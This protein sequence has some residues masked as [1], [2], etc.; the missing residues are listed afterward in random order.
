MK[1]KLNWLE[2]ALLLAPFL[3]IAAFWN[4]LPARIPVHWNARGEVDGWASSKPIEIFILPLIAVAVIALLRVLPSLD[5]K[6][7]KTLQE[8]HRMHA[9]VQILR[10]ALALFFDAIFFVQIATPLG[11]TSAGGR[12]VIWCTLLL[13]AILGNYMPALRPNYFVGLRTPWTLESPAT[14]RATHR[15]GGRLMFFGSLLLLV[16]EFFLSQTVFAFLFVTSMV[17]FVVWLFFY[18][19]H[20]FRTH[21]TTRETV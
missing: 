4:K 9:V 2:A 8:N 20:Y 11:N 16:L 6:L 14:W 12:V 7:Q 1:N 5:P 3:A 17:L 21:G 15:V 18:S 13:M 19:W 10:L